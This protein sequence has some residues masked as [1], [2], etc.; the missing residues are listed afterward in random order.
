MLKVLCAFVLMQTWIHTGYNGE[1]QEKVSFLIFSG[2]LKAH[3][4]S[5]K[6]SISMDYHLTGKGFAQNMERT[7]LSELYSGHNMISK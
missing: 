1:R 6:K 5:L 4:I 3:I 2:V 7:L